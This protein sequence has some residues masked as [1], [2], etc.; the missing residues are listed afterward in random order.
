[1][2]ASHLNVLKPLSIMT[3]NAFFSTNLLLAYTA[4]FVGTA[5]AGPS[6]ALG[7]GR[8]AVVFGIAGIKLLAT[9]F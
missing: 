9:R 3:G 4:Y 8:S 2:L 5:S 6:N 1:M 7:D